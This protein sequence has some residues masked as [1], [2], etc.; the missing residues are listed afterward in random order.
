VK[1]EDI[2]AQYIADIQSGKNTLEECLARHPESSG[3]LRPL[4]EIALKLKPVHAEVSPGFRSRARQHLIE[5]MRQPDGVYEKRRARSGLRAL[6]MGLATSLIAGLLVIAI[7][8]GTTVYASQRSL[9]GETLY[10]VKTGVEK[11][12]LTLTFDQE[13]KA[14]RHLTMAQRRVDEAAAQASRE[15]DFNTSAATRVA[16]QLDT[17]LRE[18][19]KSEPEAA[20]DMM[21]RL[22]ES[23]VH[24][25]LILDELTTAVPDTA[26]SAL[27]ETADIVRRGKLIAEVSYDNPDFL[28]SRPSVK[29]KE[30]EEGRFKLSGILTSVDGDA[31]KIDGV[32]L[33]DVRYKGTLPPLN[34]SVKVE[35]LNKNGRVFITRIEREESS[36]SEVSVE[37]RFKGT[38]DDGKVWNVGG[39]SVEVAGGN[40]P[41]EG[42][43]LRLQGTSEEGR[44]SVS[45]TETRQ[46]EELGIELEGT[47][48][49]VDAGN[50]V[51]S[52]KRA[53][54]VFKVNVSGASLRT[55]ERRS[56]TVSDL[57]RYTGR[58]VEVDGLYKKEGTLFAKAVRVEDDDDDR[59][60][61]DGRDDD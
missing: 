17:A 8:G 37:G 22:A 45:A 47:L 33:R 49:A 53:G 25:E 60:G 38:S 10:P 51:I 7:A 3:E 30:L 20:K 41:E 23:S 58:D 11:L 28:D 59:E 4:L 46:I 52:V 42:D 50:N 14:S 26:Q 21:R 44:V 2:L 15:N 36:K 55:D 24:N 12:Q 34:S 31:W 29:D 5:A 16:A 48:S 35:G 61:G 6:P 57:R 40:P 9:P 18:I 56:L 1:K 43:E 19:E 32:T 54:T 13:S 27:R 39:I